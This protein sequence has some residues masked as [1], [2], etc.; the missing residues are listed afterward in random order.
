MTRGKNEYGGAFGCPPAA[1]PPSRA[2]P[3]WASAAGP[4]PAALPLLDCIIVCYINC[5]I[6]YIA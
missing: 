5:T 2:A 6:V 4:R 1:R 3:G